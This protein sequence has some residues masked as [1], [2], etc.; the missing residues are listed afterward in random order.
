M[1]KTILLTLIIS[2]MLT[3]CT[4]NKQDFD[5][6]G[7]FEADEV[8]VSA[9]QNGEIKELNISEGNTLERNTIVGQIDVQAQKLQKQQTEAAIS[10]LQQKTVSSSAQEAVVQKQL[11]AQQAQLQ[12]LKKEKQRTENLVNA[13]AAPR[14]QLDDIDAQIDQL[15]KQMTATQAQ[16]DVYRNN[17]NTQNRSILSE[18]TPL[19][20][21]QEIINF[22][23]SKGEIVNPVTGVV[24]SK[25]AMQGEMATIGRPLYKI[26]NMD[27]L[28][29]KAYVTGQQLPKIRIGQQVTVLIDNEN[30][31]YKYYTGVI[32][33][34]SDKSEFTPKT[35]Q[36]KNERANLVYAIKV[37][38]V[39]DGY[40]KIGMYSEVVFDTSEK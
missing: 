24:L 2:V 3:S 5:A 30:K 6:A 40:L 39:N 32:S 27:T 12:T 9:Q 34:I 14:K 13:D 8:I 22:Q 16:A 38:V 31:T 10:S 15:Q 28:S 20:R 37:R 35:I 1:Q 36:T 4:N 29:L 7:N 21:S 18:R 11:A 23:I 17:A 26:A 25:Y 33:W 19:E